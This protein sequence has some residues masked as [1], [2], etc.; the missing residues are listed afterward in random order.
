MVQNV[1]GIHAVTGNQ[2]VIYGLLN[3]HFPEFPGLFGEATS[4]LEKHLLSMEFRN[5]LRGSFKLNRPMQELGNKWWHYLQAAFELK[6]LDVGEMNGFVPEE[7]ILH[8]F[9]LGQSEE[10]QKK[11][12]FKLMGWRHEASPP[13]E[14]LAR[15]KTPLHILEK[16]FRKIKINARHNPD[17]TVNRLV[18]GDQM[19]EYPA[20]AADFFEYLIYKI[21]KTLEEAPCFEDFDSI[22]ADDID[23]SVND[24]WQSE[25]LPLAILLNAVTAPQGRKLIEFLVEPKTIGQIKEHMGYSRTNSFHPEKERIHGKW[26]DLGYKIERNE[27]SRLWRIVKVC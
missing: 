20:F 25:P 10:A 7:R 13:R 5:K 18:V 9:P 12:L 27:S 16:A 11:R 8:E 21:W 2:A 26:L 19:P 15:L 3:K 24:L 23:G 17:M 4:M 22:G 14:I 6:I 1:E